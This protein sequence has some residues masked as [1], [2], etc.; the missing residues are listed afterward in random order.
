MLLNCVWFVIVKSLH[1]CCATDNI[2]WQRRLP[3]NAFGC[4][5]ARIIGSVLLG[6]RS[7]PHTWRSQAG[8]TPKSWRFRFIGLKLLRP[9][10]LWE[11]QAPTSQ[12]TTLSGICSNR[13][14]LAMADHLEGNK[15]FNHYQ[16]QVYTFPG[17]WHL[18]P[19]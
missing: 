9:Q 8:K 1:G 18:A 19:D 16:G 13:A 12:E 4:W 6:A 11:F 17:F 10:G 5:H 14:G 2:P 7:F 15:S 3:L